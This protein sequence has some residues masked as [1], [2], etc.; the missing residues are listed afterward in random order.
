MALR[1]DGYQS[2]NIP[3]GS[4]PTATQNAVAG[5]VFPQVALAWRYPWARRG[6]SYDQVIEPMVMLAAAPNGGNPG[7]IPNEDSQGFEFD[8]TSLFLRNRFPGLDRVESGQRVD[9]GLR[10]GVYGDG[11]GSTRF[12]VGQSYSAQVNNNYLPGSGLEHHVSD[13][14]GRVTVSPVAA[15]DFTYRFRLGN[16]DLALR[17]QEIAATVGPS[18]LR[19]GVNYIQIAPISN[20]PDLQKRKQLSA[21]LNAALTRY[22]SIQLLGTRD[23]ARTT[24]TVASVGTTE[25]LTSG[26]QLIYRD[27]C[28]SFITSL[29]QSGIRNGDVVP[30]TSLLFTIVFKNLGDI[31]TKV[32]DFGNI[33][34]L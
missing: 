10:G 19:L 29:T 5:R 7:T 25:T 33:G 8:E 26:A 15:L 3:I 21:S 23:F 17:R 9:Y 24:P 4:S 12:V 13:V 30:G 11:G 31:A 20:I 14:V 2:D 6:E 1:S 27:E 16:D 34:G 22:W 32:A 28:V 18:N